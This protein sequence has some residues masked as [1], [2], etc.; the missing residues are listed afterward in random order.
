MKQ[1]VPI[2]RVS[3]VSFGAGIPVSALRTSLLKTVVQLDISLCLV[4]GL[5]TLGQIM[6]DLDHTWIDVL[7]VDIEV[8][9][10]H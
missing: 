8:C 2:A 4:A 5:R 7:K 3:C 9:R 1:T 10:E 6:A